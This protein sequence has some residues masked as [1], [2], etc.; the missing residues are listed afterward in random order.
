MNWPSSVGRNLVFFMREGNLNIEGN[1]LRVYVRG[2]VLF[3][4]ED[5]F[6]ICNWNVNVF[7][8]LKIIK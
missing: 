4:S 6:G 7:N 8:R 2:N 1:A 3:L 5:F